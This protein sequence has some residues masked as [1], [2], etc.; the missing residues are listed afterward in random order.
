MASKNVLFLF[1][2]ILALSLYFG[3][4]EQRTAKAAFLSK[5]IFYPFI[6]TLHNIETTFNVKKENQQLTSEL[7]LQTLRIQAL[8]MKLEDMEIPEV[9]EINPQY[10]FLLADIIAFRGNFEERI[11]VINKGSKNGLKKG[12]PVISSHGIAG[13][14]LTTSLNY[15]I[16]LPY[17]HSTFKLGVMLDKNELQGILE[18]DIY[19]NTSMSLLPLGSDIQPGDLV[20]TSNLSLLFPKGFPVGTITRLSEASDKIHMKANIEGFTNPAS[21]DKVIVLL[22]EKDLSYEKELDN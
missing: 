2:I 9:M 22:Y 11:M 7:A 14:I 16:V 5:T 1:L 3:N 20:V 19:G 17:N 13:K 15:A 12:Y 6:S 21:L 18:S 4:H 8:Q 10:Q